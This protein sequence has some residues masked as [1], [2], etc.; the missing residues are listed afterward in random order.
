[1]AV[2]VQFEDFR[3]YFPYAPTAL[4]IKECTR[5]SALDSFDC[6]GPILDVG[7]GDGV[8]AKLVFRGRD[9]WGID[10]D[11]NE[12]G[13]AQATRVYSQIVLG[14][15]T[16]ARLPSGFFAT[17]LANCSLEHVANIGAA[18]QNIRGSL[19]PGGKLLMIVPNKEW[20]TDFLSSRALEAIG[21][22]LLAQKVREQIDSTFR[23]LQLHS[24]EE[25]SRIAAAAGL[26]VEEV[27]PIG[28][29]S[30][31]V[32]FEL[33]LLP[34]LL[35]WLNKRLTTRWTNFPGLR[36]LLTR[37]AHLLVRAAMA[38]TG[39]TAPSAELLVVARRPA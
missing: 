29:A 18:L 24:A 15:V 21:A 20:T 4:C 36:S 31:T 25:W 37:P 7:C 17:C 38:S 6:D 32:A 35:G 3:E 9:I 13:R 33:F 5:A 8:F 16:S 39:K 2:E 1:M 10:I 14:D 22:H 23:H 30:G 26:E 12:S 27:R 34:S 11:S 28:S 19:Q